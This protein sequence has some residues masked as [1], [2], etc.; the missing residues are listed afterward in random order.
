MSNG[1]SIRRT[2]VRAAALQVLLSLVIASLGPGTS[3]ARAQ[4]PPQPED[5]ALLERVAL[6]RAR[7]DL[8]RTVYG[9]P[10]KAG[11]TVGA[12]AGR[13]LR[14]DRELRLWLRTLPR[15]GPARFY[16][17]GSCDVDV[18]LAPAVLR[19][20]LV[21]LHKRFALPV[22]SDDDVSRGGRDWPMLWGSGA[23]S[24]G[25]RVEAKPPG[26]EDVSLEG[27][28][29]ARRAAEAD[30]LAALL[31][32]AGR[33]RLTAAR[34]LREFIDSTD[35]V[36]AAVTAAIEKNA[37]VRVTH[38][39]DQVCVAEAQIETVELLR[40]LNDVFL[41]T[42]QGSDFQASDFREMVIAAP[43]GAVTGTGLAIPPEKHR[44]RTPYPLIEL[45]SPG[46]VDKKIETTARFER[47]E[48]TEIDAAAAIE[49]A[50]LSGV[51]QLRLMVLDLAIR[52]GLSVGTLLSYRPALKDDVTLYLSGARVVSIT[53]SDGEESTTVRVE[54][55][56]RRLWEIVK[57]GL[58][59][60]ESDD[61]PEG[62]G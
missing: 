40:I 16:S 18:Q 31:E 55:P 49:R 5:R 13:D 47:D 20:K 59:P 4:E 37:K 60:I 36:R 3:S 25:E 57:R 33:L 10:L 29:V 14:L 7:S 44:L 17:D 21:E 42:Y 28:E 27:V 22:T 62:R 56:L 23:A 38:G 24:S 45:D 51:D 50:R 8:A 1:R 58:T 35:A 53:R 2:K 6:G 41:T 9:L 43:R 19:E 61:P 54:L 46:W 34:S 48:P 30:S 11:L 15:S 32:E 39:P 52:E 26:W 12:W